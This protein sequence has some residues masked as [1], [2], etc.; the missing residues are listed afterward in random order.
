MQWSVFLA[1]SPTRSSYV[2]VAETASVARQIE[3]LNAQGDPNSPVAVAAPWQ[4]ACSRMAETR[5]EAD[6][7]ASAV[8]SASGFRA[9]YSACRSLST[10]ELAAANPTGLVGQALDLALD[11]MTYA[12]VLV[13]HPDQPQLGWTS[14]RA[15]VD[16]GSTDCELRGELI[17]RLNLPR[18]GETAI[19]ET[20]IGR[21]SAE[22]PIFRARVRVQGREAEVLLSAAEGGEES[23]GESDEE[24]DDEDSELDAQFGFDRFSDEALLGHNALA[25]LGLAVDCRN[26]RLVPL[27]EVEVRHEVGEHGV[28]SS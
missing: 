22:S 2:G 18:T 7:A 24:S 17:E 23:G 19:F 20:A 10:A 1:Y 13:Q 14:V 25:A 11:G 21:V 26:R 12:T 27:P 3:A 8:A 15:M 16:T 5:A 28:E 9:R 6:A 4:L